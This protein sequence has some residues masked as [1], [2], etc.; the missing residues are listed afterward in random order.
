MDD[1]LLN[2]GEA[3]KFKAAVHLGIFGLAV[4][5]CSYNL[6]AWGQRRQRHLLSNTL[7]YAGLSVYE[8]VQMNRHWQDAHHG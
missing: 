8:A 5:C 6:M 7:V 2:A 4:T 3:E 1:C